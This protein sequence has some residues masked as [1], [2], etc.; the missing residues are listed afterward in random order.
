[1]SLNVKYCPLLLKM[2]AFTEKTNFLLK[3]GIILMTNY[4][5]DWPRSGY[6]NFLH[7]HYTDIYTDIYTLIF[8][9]IFTDILP[10]FYRHAET[11]SISD[12]KGVLQGHLEGH[13]RRKGIPY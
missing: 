13:I 11:T 8:I 6:V 2:P 3:A 4:L 1:M 9:L 7:Q 12:L 10:T 5:D